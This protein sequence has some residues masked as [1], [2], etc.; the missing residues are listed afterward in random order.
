[1]NNSPKITHGRDTVRVKI[2][3]RYVLV[4]FEVGDT[5]VPEYDRLLLTTFLFLYLVVSTLISLFRTY[6]IQYNFPSSL[7][8]S[9]SSVINSNMKFPHSLNRYI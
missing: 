6:L 3:V 8:R 1:M 7:I 4:I 2:R 5:S 9:N